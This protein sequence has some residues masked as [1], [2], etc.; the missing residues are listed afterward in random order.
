MN[1]RKSKMTVFIGRSCL[2]LL[3]LSAAPYTRAENTSEEN[4]GDLRIDS[5][6]SIVKRL[7]NDEKKKEDIFQIPGVSAVL[8][9]WYDFKSNLDRDYGLKFGISYTSIYKKASDAFG[10]EDSAAG[11]DLDLSGT[12]TFLGRNT[13]SPT[14]LGFDFFWRDTLNSTLSP[15]VLFTQFGGLYSTDAPFGEEDPVVGELWLQHKFNNSLG[16][17][18]GKI[19]PITAYDFFPFKNFRTDFTDF[20]HVTNNAIPLPGNGLGAFV[21]YRPEPAIMLR[22]GIH[23]ANADVQ[24][25]G[26]DTYDNELFSILEAGFDIG[27][28]PRTPG[29]PPNGHAHISLWH[30]DERDGAGIEEGWGIAGTLLQRFDNITPFIRYGYADGGAKGP[31]PVKHMANI[32]VTIDDIFGQSNDRIGLGYTWSDPANGTLGNQS[33]IDAYYR[34]QLTPQ[35]QIGPTF[36]AIFDPVNNPTEDEVYVYGLRWRI[37]L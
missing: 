6:G 13:E 1:I 3:L 25:S 24:E 2:V 8:E 29:R 5:P 34:V 10:P 33:M 14:T 18:A 20:N 32:G 16:F 19:F 26:F 4:E 23:D 7:E 35:I 22:A 28:I 15:R 11:F 36:Q 9:P 31:T 12:W 21:M 27:L 30:Q 37:N 17:R